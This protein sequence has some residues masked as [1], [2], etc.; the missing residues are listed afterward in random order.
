M[1]LDVL[2][3][4]TCSNPPPPHTHT[5]GTTREI[6]QK[7]RETV[8]DYQRIGKL[9]F[10]GDC[11]ARCSDNSDYIEN[12]D[13]VP[14]EM[15]SDSREGKNTYTHLGMTKRKAMVDY[16][17]LPREQLQFVADFNVHLMLDMTNNLS[18]QTAITLH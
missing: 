4:V 3:L 10:A 16:M 11:N 13:T 15:R 18:L 17:V 9:P 7:W 14:I 12:V 2:G 8:S 1:K 5:S 6:N